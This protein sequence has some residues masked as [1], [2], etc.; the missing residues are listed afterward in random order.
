MSALVVSWDGNVDEAERGIGIADGND[1]DVDVGSFTNSLVV[2]A[3]VGNDDKAGFLE[4]TG[5]IVGK[6]TGGETTS[7]GLCSRMLCKFE[8]SAL[9][10][11]TCGDYD[12]V[13][14]IWDG[15]DYTSGEDQLF[16]GL[17]NVDNMDS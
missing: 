1:G 2:D 16:P 10:V 4:R 5:D 9:T 6:R 14:G 12:D 8:Y 15:G 13:A 3:R 11:W 17:S 7:D